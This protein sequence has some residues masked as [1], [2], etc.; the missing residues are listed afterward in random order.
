M[1]IVKGWGGLRMYIYIYRERERDRGAAA[2]SDGPSFGAQ[3]TD[4]IAV[5]RVDVAYRPKVLDSAR[6]IQT[7]LSKN[8]RCIRCLLYVYTAKTRPPKRK[9][10]IQNP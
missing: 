8:M 6:T 2:C 5:K 1:E 10:L 7:L 3:A 4:S 9:V